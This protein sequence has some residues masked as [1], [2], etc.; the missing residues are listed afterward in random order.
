MKYFLVLFFLL[1]VQFASA[2]T[3]VI[4]LCTEETAT[5]TYV[6]ISTM[7]NGTI[8]WYIDGN[9]FATGNLLTVNWLVF[10]P[11]DHVIMAVFISDDG[12]RSE[13]VI[14]YVTLVLCDDFDIYIP[15]AFSP[16]GNGLNDEWYPVAHKY[17]DMMYWVYDRWGENVFFSHDGRWDGTYKGADCKIGIYVYVVMILD[18]RNELHQFKGNIT[19]IR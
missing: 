7:Q 6:T 5:V 2:Q 1:V 14:Y 4:H 8:Q 12:C 18:L 9:E 17:N 19:L 13:P 10:P 3:D 15:N 16:N 11:G